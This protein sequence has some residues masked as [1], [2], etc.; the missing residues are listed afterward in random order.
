[1]VQDKKDCHKRNE[2]LEKQLLDVVRWKNEEVFLY[3]VKTESGL[4]F[5]VS[6]Y[7]FV[8]HSVLQEY[9]E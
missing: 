3:Q 2:A 8:G 4:L 5:V 7:Q 9:L 6:T 1:M